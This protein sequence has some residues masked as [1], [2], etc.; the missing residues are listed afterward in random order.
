MNRAMFCN[1]VA[2]TYKPLLFFFFFFFPYQKKRKE[3]N[4]KS[5]LLSTN[6]NLNKIRQKKKNG[7]RRGPL[8][9]YEKIYLGRIRRGGGNM[10]EF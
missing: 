2:G 5:N 6:S 1:G 8:I 3:S 9:R 4:Q 10:A 7:N